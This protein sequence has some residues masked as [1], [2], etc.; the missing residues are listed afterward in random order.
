MYS[1]FLLET[2]SSVFVV[3]FFLLLFHLVLQILFYN[4]LL[5]GQPE[6]EQIH[7]IYFIRLLQICYASGFYDSS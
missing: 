4:S 3:S 2:F 5:L 1:I 6:R 7:A